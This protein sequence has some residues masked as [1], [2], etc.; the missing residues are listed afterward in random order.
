MQQFR[1]GFKHVRVFDSLGGDVESR[2]A[3][4]I[5]Q[6]EVG[7]VCL[8]H[9]LD[10]FKLLVFDCHHEWSHPLPKRFLVLRSHSCLVSHQLEDLCQ[11]HS[12]PTGC[13]IPHSEE[14]FRKL[15]LL[16]KSLG[17]LTSRVLR[18]S[19]RFLV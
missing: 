2:F 3:K 12:C 17:R 1:H 13:A 5:P 4:F 16:V 19:E 11:L 9:L 6:F 7:L 8:D 10:R 14:H 15:A 18:V